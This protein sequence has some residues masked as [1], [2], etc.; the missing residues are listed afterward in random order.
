MLSPPA[1]SL[2]SPGRP[3]SRSRL[4]LRVLILGLAGWMASTALTKRPPGDAEESQPDGAAA[5]AAPHA[6]ARALGRVQHLTVRAHRFRRVDVRG[7]RGVARTLGHRNPSGE[8]RERL[9][10]TKRALLSVVDLVA[11]QAEAGRP[12]L[13][14]SSVPPDVLKAGKALRL[15]Q[16]W[17]AF[18]DVSPARSAG[19]RYCERARRSLSGLRRSLA[20][21]PGARRRTPIVP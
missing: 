6:A 17:T 7:T 4:P 14:T 10:R 16:V 21:A 5:D 20:R 8:I 2:R 19:K 11:I 18:Q 13:H 3:S 12:Q 9:G 1:D 15:N